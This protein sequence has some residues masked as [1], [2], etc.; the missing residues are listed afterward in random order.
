[1]SARIHF[2]GMAGIVTLLLILGSGCVSSPSEVQQPPATGYMRSTVGTPDELSPLA[3]GE[4][5]NLRKVGNHW[6]CEVHG[7]TMVYNE[8]A[9]RWEPQPK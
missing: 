2:T 5:K 1:M 7:K 6:V 9:A 3:P 8:A 4:A